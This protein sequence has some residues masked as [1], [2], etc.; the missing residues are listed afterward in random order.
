MAIKRLV[1]KEQVKENVLDKLHKQLARDNIMGR[2][3]AT[4]VAEIKKIENA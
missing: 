2:S 4:L 3:T 1:T